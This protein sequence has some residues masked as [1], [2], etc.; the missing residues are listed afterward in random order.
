MQEAHLPVGPTPSW[1]SAVPRRGGGRIDLRGN[2]L[3]VAAHSSGSVVTD[4]ADGIILRSVTARQSLMR[5]SSRTAICAGVCQKL[6]ERQYGGACGRRF[7]K[8]IG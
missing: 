3:V 8:I 1:R 6:R 7:I 5:A 2:G 4:G